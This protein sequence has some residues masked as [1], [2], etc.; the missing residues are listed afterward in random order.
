MHPICKF[1][2]AAIAT[3]MLASCATAPLAPPMNQPKTGDTGVYVFR[4]NTFLISTAPEI[5]IDNQSIGKLSNNTSLFS[6]LQ[7]GNHQLSLH[8]DLFSVERAV[9]FDFNVQPHQITYIRLTWASVP[10]S[11]MASIGPGQFV[12]LGNRGWNVTVVSQPN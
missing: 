10:G 7:P 5:Y 1:F 6:Q 8:K 12:M 9:N 3:F 11:H 2:L 4:S